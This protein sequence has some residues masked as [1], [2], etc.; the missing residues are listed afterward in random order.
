LP[1]Q[2]AASPSG[3]L[4]FV[5][6]DFDGQHVA[7]D[8]A[9]ADLVSL[10][11]NGG[12]DV[13][14]FTRS[15]GTGTNEVASLQVPGGFLGANDASQTSNPPRNGIS[16]DGNFVVFLSKATNLVVGQTDSNGSGQDVFLYDRVNDKLR[17]VSRD[18]TD[19]DLV[20]PRKTANAESKDPVISGD[21]RYVAF[22]SKAT[23]LVSGQTDGNSDYDVFVWDSATGN[24]TLVSHLLGTATTAGSAGSERPSMSGNGSLVAYESKA[25]DLVSAIPTDDSNGASDVFL[26][27]RGSGNNTLVSHGFGN[28]VRTGNGASSEPVINA[29]ANGAAAFVAFT[30]LASDLLST[31]EP[32]GPDTDVFVCDRSGTL[33]SLVSHVAGDPNTPGN[34]PSSFPSIGDDADFIAFQSLATDLAFGQSDTNGQLDVFWAERQAP[35]EI[36][37]ASHTSTDARIAGNNVSRNP[38]VSGD[39]LVVV[40]ESEATDLISGQVDAP[41]TSD[42]FR[43]DPSLA[44]PSDIGL[45]SHASGMPK[46]AAN[47]VST[48]PQVSFD[49]TRVAFVSSATDL[50]HLQDDG[51]G[52][53]DVFVWR[54]DIANATAVASRKRG[55]PSTTG[56]NASGFPV[57]SANGQVVAFGSAASDLVGLDVNSFPDAFLF[58]AAFVNLGIFKSSTVPAVPGASFNGYQINVINFSAEGVVGATVS[59]ILPTNLLGATWTC[60][61]SGGATCTSIGAG[62]IAD[63]VDMPGGSSLFYQIQGTLALNPIFAPPLFN[64]ATVSPP[65]GVTEIDP[66]NSTDDDTR[67]LSPN[68]VLLLSHTDAPDPVATSGAVTYLTTITNNGPSIAV[69]VSLSVDVPP[70]AAAVSVSNPACVLGPTITCGNLGDLQP[71]QNIQVTT[72]ITATSTPGTMLSQA[73]ADSLT[74]VPVNATAD[75]LVVDPAESLIEFFTVTSTDS[76]NTLEWRTPTSGYDRTRI[77]VKAGSCPSGPTDGTATILNTFPVFEPGGGA[78]GQFPDTAVSNFTTYCYA[79]YVDRDGTGTTFS[80]GR[81]AKGRPFN[82]AITPVTWAFSTGATSVTPP[83]IGGSGVYVPS[84]DRVLYAVGRGIGGGLWLSGF[85]PLLFQQPVQSRPP[86]VPFTIGPATNVTYVSSQDGTVFAIDS[87]VGDGNPTDGIPSPIWPKN[88]ASSVQAA[89]AGWFDAF[90]A[91]PGINWILVGTRVGG[92]NVFY[93]L[94]ASTGSQVLPNGSYNGG[95]AIGIISGGAAVDYGNKRVYFT[96][97]DGGNGKTAYCL[98]FITTMGSEGFG[99]PCW[100]ASGVGDIDYGPVL[101]NDVVFV[102]SNSGNVV[103]LDASSG[104][105]SWTFGPVGL[106]KGIVVPDR[107]NDDVYVSAGTSVWGLTYLSSTAR[108]QVSSIPNPSQ[109]VFAR[110][111][112]DAYVF[113]GSSDGRLYQIDAATGTTI[114]S[115]VLGGGGAQIGVPSFDTVTNMIYVGSDAGVVYA[116]QVPLP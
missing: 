67:P 44:S 95:S 22:A 8:G 5:P 6:I 99:A 57:L 46:Q 89:P 11:T 96:S 19:P 91:D 114:E 21:G 51:N 29:N 61:P 39:G 69:Q 112:M 82:T 106:P 94:D 23:N 105:P 111:G 104:L 79:A 88:L 24:I 63:T 93:A 97:R 18:V 65:V 2:A 40:Y 33:N 34:G 43:F 1:N 76:L 38:Q 71:G 64:Q 108:W 115:V 56:N 27:D 45:V 4:G 25:I 80:P 84:N 15:G 10:D 58:E 60:T 62:N 30:S 113:V 74:S 59:D 52:Q 37:L 85:N 28:G 98:L 107:T 32:G 116:V 36:E 14:L 72:V 109:P 87:D 53:P 83:G 42:I 86:V 77:L 50:A 26:Y 12:M 70:G 13:F 9:A 17:L 47:G 68:A 3:G 102:A 7:Y 92:P 20:N 110:I 55:T 54:I 16:T 31:F 100:G 48:F 81:F 101:R 78:K 73:S 66:S 103:G 90:G 49:G 75:T 41:S 35:N